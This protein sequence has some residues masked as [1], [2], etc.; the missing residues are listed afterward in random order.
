MTCCWLFGAVLAYNHQAIN[1]FKRVDKVK[2][3]LAQKNHE[4]SLGKSEPEIRPRRSS[5]F[6]N[7]NTT[8]FVVNGS[9]IPDVP[10]DIGVCNVRLN[11][12]TKTDN[13]YR[14]R[15]QACYL[16]LTTQLRPESSTSG[17]FPARTLT[18]PTRLPSGSMVAQD[19]VLCLVS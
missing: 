4:R 3:R 9:A 14:S 13:T 19:V 1:A 18:L 8:K 16:S 17:S 7:S 15:M 11:V 10:F 2:E 5:P 12:K 6:L